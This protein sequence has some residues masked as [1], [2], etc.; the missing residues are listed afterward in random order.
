MG[1]MDAPAYLPHDT[2]WQRWKRSPLWLRVLL[3]SIVSALPLI[4][5]YELG[6]SIDCHPGD[7]DG[8]CGLGIFTG[9][10]MG[11]AGSGFMFVAGLSAT[12]IQWYRSGSDA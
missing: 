12:L 1:L 11:A 9:I 3:V 2:L 8:Q 6:V 5:G 10:L 4:A 7:R